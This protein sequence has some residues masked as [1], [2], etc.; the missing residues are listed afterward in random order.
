[1]YFHK[2]D[3]FE[4]SGQQKYEVVYSD[5]KQFVARTI[6]FLPSGK[7]RTNELLMFLNEDTTLREKYWIRKIPPISD[8][9]ETQLPILS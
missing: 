8:L 5:E 7:Y 2:G 3:F 9:K 4:V 1:M 6:C